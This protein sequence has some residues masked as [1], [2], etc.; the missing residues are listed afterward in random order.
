MKSLL[1]WYLAASIVTLVVFAWDKHC[2]A[3][4][5]RRFSERTLHSLELVG[6]WPGALAA[7]FVLRHKNR[8]ARFLVLTAAS[9]LVH[10][11]ILWLIIR[12]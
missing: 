4:G 9:V 12:H 2:A 8:K 11:V 1:L 10:L 3:R 6:G 7:I 5:A